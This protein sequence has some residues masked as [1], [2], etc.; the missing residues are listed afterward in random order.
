MEE[1]ANMVSRI[2]D[3]ERREAER[4]QELQ[5]EGNR[6]I[7]NLNEEFSKIKGAFGQ[8]VVNAK[9]QFDVIRDAQQQTVAAAAAEF[10][11]QQQ[12]QEQQRID[13][14]TLYDATSIELTRIKE[15]MN[16]IEGGSSID[17]HRPGEREGGRRE[18]DAQYLPDKD[19][20]P[21]EYEGQRE[22]WRAWK[23]DMLRMYDKN[24]G[25]RGFLE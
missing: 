2:E 18:G 8:L 9:E 12:R 13:L 10:G 24:P 1:I 16:A 14:R 20:I 3:L 23:E 11:Q 22:G 25:M 15:R 17:G 7:G 19:I 21:D 5:E 6:L 4:R